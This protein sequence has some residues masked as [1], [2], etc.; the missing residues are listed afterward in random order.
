VQRFSKLSNVK[1]LSKNLG[2]IFRCHSE[3]GPEFFKNEIV[4]LE[5]G[6]QIRSFWKSSGYIVDSEG[7][8][9]WESVVICLYI[10][11]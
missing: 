6:A 11:S 8:M 5:K 9:R 2:G 10:L 3:G 7:F 4:K 1:F